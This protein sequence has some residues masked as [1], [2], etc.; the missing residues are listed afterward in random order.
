MTL[1]SATTP[2]SRKVLKAVGY[3]QLRKDVLKVLLV[4][5]LLI[6]T[7]AVTGTHVKPFCG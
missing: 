5:L 6:I 4:T 7:E 3:R 1:T 2:A